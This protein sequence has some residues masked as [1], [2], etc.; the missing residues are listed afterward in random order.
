V[1]C[2]TSWPHS[3]ISLEDGLS[4]AKARQNKP[5]VIID[6]AVPRN[7]DAR[8][9][10]I[11]GIYLFNVD[12]L[13][14][15]IR[16]DARDHKQ[17]AESANK[18]IADEVAGFRRRMLAERVVPTIVALRQRLEELCHQEVEFL[19]REFGPFTE[20]QD[21]VLTTLA[22]HI[23]QR[24]AGSLARELR[25]LPDRTG[26]DMLTVAVHRLFHLE[27]SDS[28]VETLQEN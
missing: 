6:I 1:V 18:L 12:S 14:E 13:E 28:A 27:N 26:Q 10:D 21:Q 19:R 4:I 17:S 3:L 22:G 7:V 24:I 25:E 5:L 8:V 9:G 15:V 20:D 16:R 2:S 23:T 11:D